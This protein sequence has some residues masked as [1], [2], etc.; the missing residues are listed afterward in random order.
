M[1]DRRARMIGKLA[2]AQALLKPSQKPR[3]TAQHRDRLTGLSDEWPKDQ[4]KHWVDDEDTATSCPD[5]LR[6]DS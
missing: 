5:F 4:H 2:D 3:R 1:F 6:G